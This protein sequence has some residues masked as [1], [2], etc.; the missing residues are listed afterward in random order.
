MRI[1][2]VDDHPIV[3]DALA[4]YLE[5]IAD[6]PSGTPVSTSGVHT[7]SDAIAAL[8]SETRPELVFLDLNIDQKNHGPATL[9][10]FQ[11]SNR[12]LIPVVVFTGLSLDAPGTAEILRECY[13]E[14]SAHSILLKGANLQV[15]FR[16]LPRILHGERWLSDDT[17]SALL[18]APST[19]SAIDLTPRQWDVARGIAVGLRNKEIAKQLDLSDGNVRQ[20]VSAIYKRL[21]VYSRIAVGNAVREFA[22]LN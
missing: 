19:N 16:G 14:L 4:R 5:N 13:N 11:E 7:L 3:C 1:L 2:V 10:R 6:G 8:E 18:R 9:R 15:M 22:P 20:M 17:I 21:G 12:N